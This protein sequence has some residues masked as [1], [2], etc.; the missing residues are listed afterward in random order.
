M[1]V[2]TEFLRTDIFNY[3]LVGIIFF[4]L[5]LYITNF[6]K[7][8]KIRKEYHTFLKKL[9]NGTNIEECLKQYMYKVEEVNN[10][11]QELIAYCNKLDKDMATCIQRVGIVR[12]SAFKDMGS[13]L[14]FALA[15][16][17]E[18]NTGVVLNGI[19]SSEISNIYAK[20][21]TKGNSTYTISAEERQAIDI[22]MHAEQTHRVRE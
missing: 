8:R 12:Y 18:D 10:K 2:I 16:L 17:D 21:V 11:N 9:G 15:L 5:I 14:S 13:D 20:P 3:I 7:L 6:I 4:I 19:Y 1:D 22:A